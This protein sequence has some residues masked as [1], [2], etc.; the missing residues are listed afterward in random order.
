MKNLRI[1]A[2]FLL[3]FGMSGCNPQ[4]QTKKQSEDMM[5]KDNNFNHVAWSKNSNIYEVNIRQFTQEGTF[6]A[7]MPHLERLHKM[8]VD[9]LWFMPINPIGEKKR[10]GTL[11]SYY[12]VQDYVKVNPE[13]GSF[14]DFKAVVDKAHQLGMHVIIDWVANH[15]A[16]DNPW[17]IEHPDWYKKDSLDNFESPFDWT[18]VISLDY[19]NKGLWDGMTAAM[20]YWVEK[21]DIDGFRCDVAMLVPVEFWDS[22]RAELDKVKP[23]F[24]LAEAEQP[25]LQDKAFDAYY[26]W[27]MFNTMKAVAKGDKNVSDIW[28]EKA[29]GD[30]LFPIHAYQMLFTSNH[31][32]NSWNGT[33]H[34]MFGDATRTFGVLNWVMKGFPLIYNGQEAGLNHR[35]KF[36]D[37]DEINWDTLW[38]EKFY[39]KLIEIKNQNPALQNGEYGGEMVRIANNQEDKI[40]SFSRT[41]NGNT[42]VVMVNL[43]S[44]GVDA[45]FE[46]ENISGKYIN[47]FTKENIELTEKSSF[48]FDGWQ[49]YVISN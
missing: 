13:Y 35:L 39:S 17:T 40:F 30:S 43:S 48:H 22:A 26:G 5:E 25:N 19:E 12:A 7:F 11:G 8:G 47:S 41:L 38:A 3:A 32:E 29:K 27:E 21:A 23:V 36:F 18:D 42:V 20:K 49:Y 10:K 2:V 45:E 16:W 33:D 15:T 6:K 37:K 4:N 44:K 46:T 31:D 28:K 34:E 24:M 1:I 14:I 9:I